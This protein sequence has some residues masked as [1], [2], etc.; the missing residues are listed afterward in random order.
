MN[1][2]FSNTL[3]VV[4][5]KMLRVPFPLLKALVDAYYTR[6]Q[7]DTEEKIWTKVQ[8]LALLAFEDNVDTR[9][10]IRLSKEQAAACISWS[11]I[12]NNLEQF[13]MRYI[14]DKI[15]KQAKSPSRGT[16]A[17]SAMSSLKQ[18]IGFLV[19]EFGVIK[20]DELLLDALIKQGNIATHEPHKKFH[21]E[22]DI[23]KQLVAR[24]Q[25]FKVA[26]KMKNQPPM[27]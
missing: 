16:P 9:V 14:A 1:F 25:S 23:Q 19:M 5:E 27:Y 8:D 2:S 21:M 15:R 13:V 10:F 7:K 22:L 17:L 11:I 6:A 12:R 24:Y 20:N 26:F 3:A 18:K 4:N